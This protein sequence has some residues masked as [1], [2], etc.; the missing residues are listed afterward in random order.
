MIAKREYKSPGAWRVG[1]DEMGKCGQKLQTSS[2]K[3]NIMG[4]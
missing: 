4:M 3:I 2:Y 1:V